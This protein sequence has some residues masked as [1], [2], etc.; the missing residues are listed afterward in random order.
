MVDHLHQN[1]PP[2]IWPLSAKINRGK[3]VASHDTRFS[4]GLAYLSV[5]G[6]R[7]S[8]VCPGVDL[9]LH[10]HSFSIEL[11][12]PL[13]LPSRLSLCPGQLIILFD[14]PAPFLFM[15]FVCKVIAIFIFVTNIIL[16]I[17]ALFCRLYIASLP[18]ALFCLRLNRRGRPFAYYSASIIHHSAVF[19]LLSSDFKFLRVVGG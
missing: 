9:L 13:S 18:V 10:F 5:P 12:L 7:D 15:V 8:L 6:N 3:V 2:P 17:I 19:I 14:H 11:F 4:E 16:L 1:Q